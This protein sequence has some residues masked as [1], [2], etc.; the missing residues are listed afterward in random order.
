M[1]AVA[2]GGNG[3][4][5]AQHFLIYFVVLGHEDHEAV[6]ARGVGRVDGIDELRLMARNDREAVAFA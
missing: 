6:S 4:L 1:V 5:L 2:G 3:E